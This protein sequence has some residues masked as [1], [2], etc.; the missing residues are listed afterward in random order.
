MLG[1]LLKMQQTLYFFS[2]KVSVMSLFLSFFIFC[3]LEYAVLLSILSLSVCDV[4]GIW[5]FKLFVIV[6]SSS[7]CTLFMLFVSDGSC[8]YEFLEIWCCFGS[9]IFLFLLGFVF[10]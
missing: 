8:L 9:S 3:E 2:Y 5:R 4:H 6:I 10:M 1:F 7:S